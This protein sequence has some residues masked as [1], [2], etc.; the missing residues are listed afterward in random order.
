M[1]NI[2]DRRCCCFFFLLRLVF[3][4]FFEGEGEHDGQPYHDG[5]V[6]EIEDAGAEAEE[7]H[8]HEVG[9]GG[10]EDAVVDVADAAADDEA[11]ADDLPLVEGL[12][13]HGVQRE[14]TQ[15]DGRK[16]VQN[17]RPYPVGEVGTEAEEGPSVFDV[18]ESKKV[19][20]VRFCR[21]KLQGVAGPYFGPLIQANVGGYDAQHEED[22]C[23]FLIHGV[24]IGKENLVI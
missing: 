11:H 15:K 7:S 14:G 24:K 17:Q 8:V 2:L 9:D 10:V 21:A 19:I 20:P 12:G 22:T 16:E 13:K 4:V 23:P 5:D 6:S 1:I 3:G 18:D